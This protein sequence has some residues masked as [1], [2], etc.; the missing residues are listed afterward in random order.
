[1]TARMG[2]RLRYRA[3]TGARFQSLLEDDVVCP[4]SRGQPR[5]AHRTAGSICLG[6][7][8]ALAPV[9]AS[10]A[11]RSLC[12][13]SADHPSGGVPDCGRETCPSTPR[14]QDVVVF[15][16]V[17]RPRRPL[18]AAR[19]L[20]GEIPNWNRASHLTDERGIIPGLRAGGV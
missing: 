15:R 4:C 19:Q 18:A 1:P 14:L 5:R 9:L 6:D 16:A 20:S 17:R 8:L 10:V 2:D 11:C 7:S 12:R 3:T 13:E